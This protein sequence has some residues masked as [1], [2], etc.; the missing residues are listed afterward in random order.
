MGG[1]AVRLRSA[2][3]G[4]TPPVLLLHG[5][6]FSSKTWE[7]LGTLA[8][9]AGGGYLALAVDLPGFGET[10]AIEPSDEAARGA[11]LGQLIDALGIE[12]PVIVSP[13]MSGS[14]SL[15]FLASRAERVSGFVPVGVAGSER[16]LEALAG[17]EVPTLVV[18][19]G[20]DGTTP[21]EDGRALAAAIPGAELSVFEGA[22]HP[23]YL[24][25]PEAFHRALLDFLE[26]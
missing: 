13:S 17:I 18:W 3:T 4:G 10:P 26:D 23:C 14:F 5:G 15:P 20:N 25:E 21:L 7:E 19:G 6:R 1:T 22:S 12:P 11:F 24:D 16:W 9:L 8:V 2:G